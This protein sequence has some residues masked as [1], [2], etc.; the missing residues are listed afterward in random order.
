M[1]MLIHPISPSTMGMARCNIGL[2]SLAGFSTPR[3]PKGKMGIV[4]KFDHNM[5][6]EAARLSLQEVRSQW[7][8]RK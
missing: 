2:I 4:N 5:R 6:T 8:M 7:S 1:P 3:S